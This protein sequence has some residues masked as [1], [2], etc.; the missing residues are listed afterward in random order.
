[1]HFLVLDYVI[2]ITD[3][4]SDPAKIRATNLLRLSFYDICTT[5]TTLDGKSFNPMT[6]ADAD[7]IVEFVRDMPKK[8]FNIY[9]HCEAGVSRS[10]GVAAAISEYLYWDNVRFYEKKIP[11][12]W[13][14]KLLLDKLHQSGIPRREKN[15]GELM[16]DKKQDEHKGHYQDSNGYW[17]SKRSTE[18]RIDQI[19]DEQKEH[20]KKMEAKRDE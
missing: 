1:M 19:E 16:T 5:I 20:K 13:C 17:Q 12:P 3:P 11:N 8:I 6:E 14:Y 18:S 15:W 10:A 2:S 9:I 7:K 4:E